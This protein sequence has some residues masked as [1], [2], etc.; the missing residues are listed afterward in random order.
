[1]TFP[2]SL[3]ALPPTVGL[4][5]FGAFGRL[6]ARYLQPHAPLLAFDPLL[7]QAGERDGVRLATL[8][9]AA[10]CP[11]V[12]LAMPVE[13]LR[14]VLESIRPHLRPGSLVVDVGSV[15]Q[16]PAALLRE[17]LPLGVEAVGTHPLFGP[18]SAAGGIRGLSVAVCPVRGTRPARR[19][20]ALLRSRLGLRPF[21]S[22]PEAHD[23]EAA[24]VQGL[25]HLIAK[26]L[27]R[28]EP[29]P[30]RLSTRSFELMMQAVE[31][32]R[33]DAQEVFLAIERDNPHAREVRN[34]FLDL[35]AALGRELDN[36]AEPARRV[37]LPQSA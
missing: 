4:I 35:V 36:H 28:M 13:R 37:T 19:L 8:A 26:V 18:Q 9:G 2:S 3:H 27:V 17:L 5:G 33:H 31:M 12:I 6:I 7:P 15:K 14:E 34:R 10:A 29:F 11:V 23:R 20:A 21:L 25:T 22:T 16:R 24:V 32:V 30:T 1:M